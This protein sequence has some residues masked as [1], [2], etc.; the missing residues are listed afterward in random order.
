LI[1]FA[2]DRAIA[3]YTLVDQLPQ[4]E[5]ELEALQQQLIRDGNVIAFPDTSILNLNWDEWK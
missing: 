5:R 2:L 1:D 3:P 4:P